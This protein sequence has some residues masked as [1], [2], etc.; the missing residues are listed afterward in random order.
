MDFLMLGGGFYCPDIRKC[1]VWDLK[2]IVMDFSLEGLVKLRSF[3]D[4]APLCKRTLSE[5]EVFYNDF[6]GT[7]FKSKCSSCAARRYRSGI[8]SARDWYKKWCF[9]KGYDYDTVQLPNV[10]KRGRPRKEVSD[11]CVG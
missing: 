6:F 9:K 7:S 4:E 2:G 10:V 3:I 11:E 1:F 5:L 8:L